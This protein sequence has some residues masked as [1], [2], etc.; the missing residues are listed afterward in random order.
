MKSRAGSPSSRDCATKR[1]AARATQ[2]G[3]TGEATSAEERRSADG[4]T[5]GMHGDGMADGGGSAHSLRVRGRWPDLLWVQAM[6]A[7]PKLLLGR[8]IRHWAAE[9][10]TGQFDGDRIEERQLA[11]DKGRCGCL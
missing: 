10:I 3:R 2:S 7:E 5:E 9:W 4:V 1:R 11:V 8:L 6:D